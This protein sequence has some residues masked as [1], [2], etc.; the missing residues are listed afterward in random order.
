[1]STNYWLYRSVEIDII[2]LSKKEK[3]DVKHDRSLEI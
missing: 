3:F 2:L 1:M